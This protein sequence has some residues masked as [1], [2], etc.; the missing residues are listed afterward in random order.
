[1]VGGHQGLGVTHQLLVM[2]D[3]CQRRL[4]LLRQRCVLAQRSG[5][6]G[7]LRLACG[8]DRLQERGS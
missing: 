2:G 8:D 1:M 4:P 6:R 7:Q 5:Q 3:D